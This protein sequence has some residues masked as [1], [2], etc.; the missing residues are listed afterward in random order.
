V[1]SQLDTHLPQPPVPTAS[2]LGFQEENG[3]RRVMERLS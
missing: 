2:G 3:N 1:L